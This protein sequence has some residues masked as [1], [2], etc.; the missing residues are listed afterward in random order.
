MKSLLIQHLKSVNLSV[1]ALISSYSESKSSI[2]SDLICRFILDLLGQNKDTMIFKNKVKLD[3]AETKATSSAYVKITI[4]M[5]L[6]LL[7]VFFCSYA[8]L[9]GYLKGLDWQKQYLKLCIFQISLSKG[10]FVISY[11]L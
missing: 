5:F 9:K 11:P 8:I 4:I 10:K 6:V 3:L 1:N 2:G 7:N